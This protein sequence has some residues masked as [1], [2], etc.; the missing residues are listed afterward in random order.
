MPYLYNKLDKNG[1]TGRQGYQ[2]HFHLLFFKQLLKRALFIL[3]D[4]DT[5]S[6]WTL[7]MIYSNYNL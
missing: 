5:A 7:I 3:D 6:F 1:G 4:G 2:A